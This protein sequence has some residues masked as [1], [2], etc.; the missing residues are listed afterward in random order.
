VG[1]IPVV[2]DYD[3]DGKSD[4]AVFRPSNGVWYIVKSRTGFGFTY[5]WG[6]AGD[7]P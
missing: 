3:G 5:V 7:I 1:D 4:I 2:G 6:G